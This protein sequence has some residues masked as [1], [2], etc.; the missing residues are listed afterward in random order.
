MLCRKGI[1]ALLWN[2]KIQAWHPKTHRWKQ[3]R[4]AERM[5]NELNWMTKSQKWLSCNKAGHL[6]RALT[7]YLSFCWWWWWPWCTNCH[8]ESWYPPYLPRPSFYQS[9]SGG[10]E[11]SFDLHIQFLIQRHQS[12]APFR[13]GLLTAI[14]SVNKLKSQ[15]PSILDDMSRFHHLFI[16]RWSVAKNL[17][18]YGA[19]TAVQTKRDIARHVGSI[20]EYHERHWTWKISEFKDALTPHLGKSICAKRLGATYN[21]LFAGSQLL[22]Q[23]SKWATNKAI[24]S[25]DVTLSLST[26]STLSW[27]LI[28]LQVVWLIT[29]ELRLNNFSEEPLHRTSGS[30]ASNNPKTKCT[31]CYNK[32]KRTVSWHDRSV[33]I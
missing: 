7:Y 26:T 29:Y 12:D 27:H 17:N 28:S 6:R 15:L 11:W 2:W 30:I 19:S 16:S 8:T 25:N 9:K 21:N 4:I 22:L 5:N 23:Q 20:C 18:P 24:P 13:R 32:L 1:F 14:P 33:S 3:E 10:K 31:L